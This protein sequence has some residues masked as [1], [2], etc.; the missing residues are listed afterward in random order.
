MYETA[1]LN[2]AHIVERVRQALGVTAE[3][4]NLRG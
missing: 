3:V 1:Q 4:V 2:A